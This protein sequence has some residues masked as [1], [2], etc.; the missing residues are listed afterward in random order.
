MSPNF[1]TLTEYYLA[2]MEYSKKPKKVV[3]CIPTI[4]KPYQCLLD[5]LE[6]AT[7]FIEQKGYETFLITEVGSPYVSHARATLLRKALDAKPDIIIFLDHDLSFDPDDLLKLIETEGAYVCG[8]YRY[9]KPEVEYMGS[10]LTEPD[11]TPKVRESDG[12]LYA[13]SAPAGFMKITPG[14]VNSMIEKYPDLCYGERHTP[15]VDLFRHGAYNYTWIGEDYMCSLR[16]IEA[17]F[18]LF[19][20]PDLNINHHTHEEEFKGNFHEFLLRQPGG[21]NAS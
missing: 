19:I 10:L 15:H 16:W 7:V 6:A 18:D 8:T 14:M 4:T 2:D 17:G 12:A 11:G 13:Y 5:S 21:S 20:V 1:M 3:F 9:K